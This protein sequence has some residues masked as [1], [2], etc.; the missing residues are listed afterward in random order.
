VGARDRG[1]GVSL[2]SRSQSHTRRHKC[3]FGFFLFFL[4]FSSRFLT[5][6]RSCNGH[7]PLI[8]QE[9]RARAGQKVQPRRARQS[10]KLNSSKAL[11][12]GEKRKIKSAWL[13]VCRTCKVSVALCSRTLRGSSGFFKFFSSHPNLLAVVQRARPSLNPRGTCPRW[14]ES[15]AAPSKTK[16]CTQQFQ[17]TNEGE[18]IFSVLNC[19]IFTIFANDYSQARLLIL[20]SQ[21]LV[22]LRSSQCLSPSLRNLLYAP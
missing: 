10:S 11:R 22:A 5:S 15:P 4:T 18:N 21:S 8:I 12:R 17:S 20:H 14:A 3:L 1:S 9:G 19:T 6:T 7:A 2:R 16:L 13:S